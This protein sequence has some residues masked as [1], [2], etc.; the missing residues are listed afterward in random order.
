MF[1]KPENFATANKSTIEA[2]LTFGNTAFASAE[3]F[4]ALNL[5]TARTMFEESVAN[6][7]AMLG[8]KDVQE[9]V[10]LQAAFAQPAVDHAVAYS[11]S[12]YEIATQTKDELSKVV[13]AQVADA[14][15]GATTMLD[16]A[17]KNAPAGSDAVIATIKSAISATNSAYDSI[18]KTAKQVTDMAEA[19]VAAAT[20]ATVKAAGATV[21][22]MKKAA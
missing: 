21:A 9:F 2:A 13:D 1:T 14:K 4:A 7:K 12:V 15:V 3:R 20:D 17:F 16:K 19:N 6:T 18:A 22:K 10:S 11:R 8:A 5:N